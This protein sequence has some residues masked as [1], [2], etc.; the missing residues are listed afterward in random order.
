MRIPD[1]DTQK[2]EEVVNYS[3][4][5]WLF[6]ITDAPYSIFLRISVGLIFSTQGF[7]KYI[8]PNWA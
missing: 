7:L 8:D 3:L 6:G 1:T 5:R 4:F 2:E